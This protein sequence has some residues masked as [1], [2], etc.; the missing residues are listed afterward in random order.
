MVLCAL[1][2]AMAQCGMNRGAVILDE[3]ERIEQNGRVIDVVP[4]WRWLLEADE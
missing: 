2:A 4:A 3:A 1:Q